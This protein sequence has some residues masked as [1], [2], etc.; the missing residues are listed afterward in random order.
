MRA[1]GDGAVT[2][3]GGFNGE[4][5]EDGMATTSRLRIARTAGGVVRVG[6]RSGRSARRASPAS[7]SR[8]AQT[9]TPSPYRRAQFSYTMRARSSG[10][11][12][13]KYRSTT[14]RDSGHVVSV[15]G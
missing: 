11:T 10:F 9:V 14:A 8:A 6:G 2:G 7:E 1:R 13:A 4:M 5:P 3:A 12:P 15:C